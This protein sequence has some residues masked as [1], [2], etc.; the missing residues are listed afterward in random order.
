M[1]IK[2][3][4]EGGGMSQ[5]TASKGPLKSSFLKGNAGWSTEAATWGCLED[6]ESLRAMS[7]MGTISSQLCLSRVSCS[8]EA[9]KI[10]GTAD[11]MDD[12]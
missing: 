5:Q 9:L 1:L 12:V 10:C 7:L 11:A 2:E 6:K 4:S 8:P 3:G